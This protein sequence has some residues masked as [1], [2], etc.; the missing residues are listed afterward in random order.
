MASNSYTNEKTERCSSQM[1]NSESWAF[2][3]S[4]EVRSLTRSCRRSQVDL[5][6]YQHST[7]SLSSSSTTEVRVR[8]GQHSMND[9]LSERRLRWLGHVIRMDH[10]RIPWQALLRKV[11]GF[12]TGPVRPRTNWRSTVNKDLLRMESPG[13]K[14]RWQLIKQI[15]MASKCGP[16]QVGSWGH[17][18]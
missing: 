7:A 9:I 6:V 1:A 17:R 10:Q 4:T 15:R 18:S 13:R 12:K 5:Y 2:P 3:G 16:M 11:P 8:T 14:F